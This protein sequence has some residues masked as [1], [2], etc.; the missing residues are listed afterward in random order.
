VYI[1]LPGVPM[2]LILL[3]LALDSCSID[4]RSDSTFMVLSVIRLRYPYES[5]PNL[6]RVPYERL[7]PFP[8]IVRSLQPSHEKPVAA[9]YL[10]EIEHALWARYA[11][12]TF[13]FGHDT[14][15]IIE[16]LNSAWDRL[17]FLPVL[18]IIDGIW[19]TVMKQFYNRRIRRQ[20]STYLTDSIMAKYQE[21]IKHSRRYRV[22]ESGNGIF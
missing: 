22:Y 4:E 8:L 19:T 3:S 18:Q 5:P 7:S 10:D 14:S 12:P 2:T 13:R 17:W 1:Y 20:Q 11:F 6:L 9:Q 16:S 21:R 15:N